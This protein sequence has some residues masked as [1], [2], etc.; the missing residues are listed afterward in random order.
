MRT[1]LFLASLLLLV[2]GCGGDD[3]GDMGPGPGD[4]ATARDMAVADLRSVDQSAPADLSSA[5]DLAVPADLSAPAD[6]TVPADFTLICPPDDGG[7][8]ACSGQCVETASDPKN[9]GGCGLACAAANAQLSCDRGQCGIASC[10]MGFADCDKS[11]ADGCEAHLATDPLN[12]NACGTAC[13]VNDTCAAGACQAATLAFATPGLILSFPG[14]SRPQQAVAGDFN[15]D[16]KLDLFAVSS[17]SGQ[18]QLFPGN[19]DATFQ[20]PM[21]SQIG[22]NLAVVGGDFNGDGKLDAATI[23]Y[24]AVRVFLGKGDGTFQAAAPYAMGT[25]P[26]GLATADLD[27]KNGPDLVIADYMAGGFDV[28]LN[29]GNG[30]FGAPA[31]S[32]SGAHA[33]DVAIADWDG[34]GK[35]DLAVANLF[36][37]AISIHLG[38]GD[39]TFTTGMPLAIMTVSKLAAGDIDGDGR[40]DLAGI[41]GGGD[42]QVF[43]GKGDGTFGAPFA[44]YGLGGSGGLAI[45]DFNRDGRND[46]VTSNETNG[47]VTVFLGSGDAVTPLQYTDMFPMMINVFSVGN[48]PR[49]PTIA[50]MNR[51]GLPD[52][53]TCNDQNGGD[54]VDVLVNKTM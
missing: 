41:D 38:A 49:Q 21:I 39:G 51:D 7:A 15:G 25:T 8:M 47:T 52:I 14:N 29:Q 22:Q 23:G 36:D 5:P 32:A 12:C 24:S 11:Y 44:F 50:D 20:G 10:N 16:G 53:I 37:N 31:F 1:T 40:A 42:G 34:D 43:I 2:A 19:G 33:I 17:N 28:L 3:G 18:A 48:S 45:A 54:S 35:L 26:G 9:C 6:L 46:V 27:G 30:T 4:Q 13:A